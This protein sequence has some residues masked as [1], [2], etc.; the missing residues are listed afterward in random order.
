M[1]ECPLLA[2][3]GHALP[4]AECPLSGVKQTSPR[5]GGCR[6]KHPMRWTLPPV[7]GVTN[8]FLT[9]LQK[10]EIENFGS[11]FQD[12]P[13]GDGSIGDEKVRWA[14][15]KLFR[16]QFVCPGC[17]GKRFKRPLVLTKPVCARERCET[18]FRFTASSCASTSQR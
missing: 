6:P 3:S 17:G 14:E 18:Q 7:P 2:Q 12:G 10:G 5:L 9:S 15:L 16:D 13:Y 11:H 4:L 8:R 1:S